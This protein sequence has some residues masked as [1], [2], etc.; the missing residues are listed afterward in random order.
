M[1]W[2]KK[3]PRLVRTDETGRVQGMDGVTVVGCDKQAPCGG[4]SCVRKLHVA[5]AAAPASWPMP[6]EQL[7]LRLNM[8][9]E[10]TVIAAGRHL[11]TR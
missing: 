1:K 10:G 2:V 5:A 4:V 8:T 11:I 7:E 3:F 6:G 9:W